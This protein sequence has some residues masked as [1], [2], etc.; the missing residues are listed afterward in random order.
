MK[1]S[2]IQS[3]GECGKEKISARIKGK[4]YRT[5]VRPAMLYGLETVSLRK[6]QESELERLRGGS[7]SGR[8]C[9]ASG[10]SA[11]RFGPAR[12][13]DPGDKCSDRCTTNSNIKGTSEV[14]KT[15]DHISDTQLAP[16]HDARDVNEWKRYME[17]KYAVV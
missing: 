7:G 15:T 12:S 13:G 11:P 2:R 14:K 5:V 9:A 4:V 6:R 17:D 16:S 10:D 3:N 8:R 1:V